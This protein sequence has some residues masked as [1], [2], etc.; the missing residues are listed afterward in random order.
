MYK[1]G[2]IVKIN[3]DKVLDKYKKYNKEYEIIKIIE[4]CEG[5]KL[6]KLKNVPNYGTEEMLIK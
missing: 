2:D 1:I 4:T 3:L 6:Y 5:K